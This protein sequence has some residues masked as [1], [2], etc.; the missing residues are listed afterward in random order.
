MRTLTIGELAQTCKVNLETLRYYE[1]VG[2]MQPPPRSSSG[3]R[4]YP[5][6]AAE[7]LAFI[8]RAQ[9]LGFTLTEIRELLHLKQEKGELCTDVVKS[10]DTKLVEVDRKI[11]D[12]RSIR[13][14]LGKMKEL[15]HGDCLIGDCPILENLEHSPKVG[16]HESSRRLHG[17]VS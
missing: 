10:I 16:D 2:L 14:A 4:Q 7:R 17:S 12:L 3:H 15:C 5:A 11:A 6:S 9:S 13:S 1:R 8:R